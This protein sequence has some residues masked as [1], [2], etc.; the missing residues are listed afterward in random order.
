VTGSRCPY[1]AGVLADAPRAHQPWD[2]TILDLGE[3][4]VAPTKGALVPG[5]ALVISKEHT[6]CVGALA[7]RKLGALRDAIDAT[8]AL[9]T[10]AFGPTTVFEHGPN[11]PGTALGCGVDHLHVH[12]V[13]LRFSLRA[14]L[15]RMLPQLKWDLIPGFET[16]ANLHADA[17]SYVWVREPGEGVFGCE[18]PI[19]LRQPLRRA[20]ALELGRPNEFDYTQFPEVSNVDLTHQRL[21]RF[22][23]G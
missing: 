20:I 12:V 22:L 11:A 4:V 18:P 13:P 1:C 8:D 3:Y 17:R 23:H 9:I 21:G 16:L 5:W 14:A 7:S 6:I 2:V 10:K 19:G 15:D